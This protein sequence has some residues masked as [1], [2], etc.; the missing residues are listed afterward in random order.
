MTE[1]RRSEDSQEGPF[2]RPKFCWVIDDDTGKRV[3][4]RL[5]MKD[6]DGRHKYRGEVRWRD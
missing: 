5:W 4:V 6:S 2:W 3:G 1:G